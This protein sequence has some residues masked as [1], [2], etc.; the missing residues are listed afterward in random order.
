MQAWMFSITSSVSLSSSSPA[1]LAYIWPITQ[2][3]AIGSRGP[4]TRVHTI[5]HTPVT[6]RT[7]LI[8]L[9]QI[10]K[11]TNPVQKLARCCK[12][13]LWRNISRAQ[14]SSVTLSI[15]PLNPFSLLVDISFT[16]FKASTVLFVNLPFLVV[17][18]RA[19][20]CSSN[21]KAQINIDRR[22]TISDS[23][24]I[25][26]DLGVV[27]ADTTPVLKGLRLSS[28]IW[29][30]TGLSHW[31]FHHIFRIKG[32]GLFHLHVRSSKLC[33]RKS[34]ECYFLLCCSHLPLHTYQVPAQRFL[35][36]E[37]QF[38]ELLSCFLC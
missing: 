20:A 38:N 4:S 32:I 9:Q 27:L 10:E 15:A 3:S 11:R 24:S 18:G 1:P 5:N 14:I 30:N 35:L 21:V 25:F 28:A 2:K 23:S 13:L 31:L 37:R 34:N 29:F 17:C 33:C 16:W 8:I 36:F 12:A 26:M 6:Q 7:A 22:L 19:V